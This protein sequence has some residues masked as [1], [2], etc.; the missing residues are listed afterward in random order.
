MGTK[1]KLAQELNR[2]REVGIDLVA[3]C[4]NDLLCV[5]ATPLFF[6][7]YWATEKL[8]PRVGNSL[9]E[10]ILEGCKLSEM[11]LVGGETAEMPDLYRPN[12]YD[13][14]GFVVGEVSADRVLD[15]TRMREGDSLVALP[16]SGFHANGYSLIRKLVHKEERELK[17]K[18]LIPTRI[19]WNWIQD[20]LSSGWITGAAHITGGGLRNITRMHPLFNY[21]I[22]DN[23]FLKRAPEF[24]RV[25]YERSQQGPWE[26]C[27]VFNMGIG[28]VIATSCPEKILDALG[29]RGR[30]GF[31][32]GHIS[33]GEG[34]LFLKGKK[35]NN[36]RD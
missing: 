1:I 20:F 18:L 7:D 13:L 25:I 30:Q 33:K 4:V 6:L 21:Y 19:Y 29:K 3:M 8:D 14:A 10:G 28:F 35:F 23:S 2:H 24:M 34:T 9:I 22:E 27:K 17:E 26:L 11:A 15:G 12:E 16:S 5:G 31:L 32:L 36:E